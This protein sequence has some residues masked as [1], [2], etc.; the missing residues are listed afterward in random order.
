MSKALIKFDV[1]EIFRFVVNGFFA[2]AIHFCVL[3]FCL[4]ILLL[5]SAGLSNGIAAIF[6]IATSFLGSRLFV[7]RSRSASIASQG[8]RF[9]AGYS[10]FALIHASVLFLWTDVW[11]FDY[12]I[13]F[14][15]A[16]GI[17]MALSFLFNKFV[18]FR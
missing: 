3:T 12:R 15:I 9:L 17:Q 18:V 10:L 4:E 2:T 14:L 16:T 7:F 1:P 6:G 13:G 5:N 11:R 8:L